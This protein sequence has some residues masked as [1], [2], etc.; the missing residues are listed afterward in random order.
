MVCKKRVCGI[1][2]SCW[3]RSCSKVNSCG[4]G[5]DKEVSLNQLLLSLCN[6]CFAS[7]KL[8]MAAK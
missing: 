3:A 5:C 6:V 8:A 4:V 2:E 7:G 1:P